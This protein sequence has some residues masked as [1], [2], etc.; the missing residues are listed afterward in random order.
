M[1]SPAVGLFEAKSRLSE[2]VAPAEVGEEVIIMR[3]NKAV[4]KI[5]PPVVSPM[6]L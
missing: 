5:V 6:K 1:P 2:F 4:A 3:H